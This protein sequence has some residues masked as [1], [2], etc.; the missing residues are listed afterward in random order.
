MRF[1]DFRKKYRI[2]PVIPSAVVVRE[3]QA[4][5]QVTRNQLCRWAKNGK[6]ISLRKGMYAFHP[7]EIAAAPEVLYIA[8][9]LC[10]PSYVSMEYA[11]SLYELIPE[12]VTV[13]TS[14]TTRKTMSFKNAIGHFAYQ[15]VV[16]RAFRGF[17]Q[18]KQEH[19]RQVFVA[20]PEKAVLDFLY[21]NASKFRKDFEG[22]LIGSF[23]FQNLETLDLE[24][25]AELSECYGN[26]NLSRLTNQLMDLIRK[27]K[28]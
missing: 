13:V 7:E 24:R 16:P 5:Y 27:E 25:M 14:V 11:L 9:R 12:Y 3:D 26:G 19:D 2:W 18:E 17:R 6:L 4:E 28:T 23:R 21:L 10:E 1:D 15:H 20:E 22:V 8:N